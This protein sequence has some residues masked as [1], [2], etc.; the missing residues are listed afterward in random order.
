MKSDTTRVVSPPIV[1]P[2]CDPGSDSSWRCNQKVITLLG[3]ALLRSFFWTKG[4][5]AVISKRL[6]LLLFAAMWEYGVVAAAKFSL[7]IVGEQEAAQH[8]LFLISNKSYWLFAPATPLLTSTLLF[9]CHA[10]FSFKQL[11]YLPVGGDDNWEWR[12]DWRENGRIKN[13]FLENVGFCCS[14]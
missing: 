9:S 6:C 1:V 12:F 3:A 5:S 7:Y 2:V 8:K 11:N 4:C 13:N 10:L 14:E